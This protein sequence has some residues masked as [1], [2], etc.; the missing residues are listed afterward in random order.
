[1]ATT[2][3]MGPLAGLGWLKNGIN[4][5]R[6][7]PKAIFGGAAVL[8]GAAMVPSLVTLP[9]QLG[10]EPGVAALVAIMAASVL[11]SLAMVPMMG[12]YL[13]LVDAAENGRDAG[14][15]MLFAP[16]RRGGGGWRLVGFALLLM[17]VYV[18]AMCLVLAVAGFG[19]LSWY[20]QLIAAS[21]AE[22]A[23]QAALIGQMPPGLG[24]VLA[25]GVVLMLY[26]SGLYAIGLGQVALTPRGV[27]AALGDG[28]LGSLKNLLPLLL[29]A[30]A[31]LVVGA[32][33]AIVIGIAV[34]L[35]AVAGALVAPW[36][37]VVLVLPVY[38]GLMLVMYVV[39]F[40]VLYHLWRDVCSAGSGM[41]P[42][43]G[44]AVSA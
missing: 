30:V 21:A 37:A 28:V 16:Y 6:R 33:A 23:A 8:L 1:M 38:L 27:L 40:G 35:L 15:R 39:M 34:G 7:N 9:L 44:G 32:V 25:L 22:P 12:G 11:A 42:A 36:L 5:G 19:W 41:V 26:L 29:L 2:R 3:A 17:A 31:G 43:D 20:L 4:L 10:G 13:Q 24:M 18:I 14:V